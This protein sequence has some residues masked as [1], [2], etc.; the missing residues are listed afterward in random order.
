MD[1]PFKILFDRLELI[2]G[3]I[4]KLLSEKVTLKTAITG[5]D[6][7]L[8]I[9]QAATFLNIKKAT[10]YT[11]VSKRGV[12]HMKKSKRLY[13]SKVELIVWLKQGKKKTLAEIR[14]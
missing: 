2:D 12:P 9:E 8:T 5:Q 13:F 14:A 1:N 11:M 3:K 6:E 10:L 7:F 4:D